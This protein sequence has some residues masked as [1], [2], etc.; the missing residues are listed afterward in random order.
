MAGTLRKRCKVCHGVYFRRQ[1]DG[2]PYYHVCPALGVDADGQPIPRPG[3]R[4]E[5][6]D[7]NA[8]G[9]LK[10]TISEGPGADDT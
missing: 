3:G 2:Y 5:N 6:I 1:A 7:T 10:G 8:D 9:T 4:N